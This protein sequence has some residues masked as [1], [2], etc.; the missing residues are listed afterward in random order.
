[1]VGVSIVRTN[2]NTEPK[3]SVGNVA[4]CLIACFKALP[5]RVISIVGIRAITD[6]LI[7]IPVSK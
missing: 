4:N 3:R 2:K 1:M 6:T 5:R 7:G